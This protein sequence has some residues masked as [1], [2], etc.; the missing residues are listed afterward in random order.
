MN[1][2]SSRDFVH[3]LHQSLLSMRALQA[4]ELNGKQLAATGIVEVFRVQW[5]RIG[6]GANSTVTFLPARSVYNEIRSFDL[7]AT[8]LRRGSQAPPLR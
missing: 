6:Q 7:N 5:V 4:D 2:M 8:L 3:D 1:E